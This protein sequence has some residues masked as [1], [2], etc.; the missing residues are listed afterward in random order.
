[1]LGSAELG[2]RPRARFVGAGWIGLGVRMMASRP[3]RTLATAA[4]LAASAAV[5]L[6]MLAL[7]S[8]LDALEH[9]PGSVGKR[10][11]LTAHG[12]APGLDRIAALPGVAAAA[13]R[14]TVDVADSYQLGETFQ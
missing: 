5:V 3:V 12:S 10:Y 14:F 2:A 13:Q 4:V 11:Q 8:L 1:M 9:D 6:L 7:A